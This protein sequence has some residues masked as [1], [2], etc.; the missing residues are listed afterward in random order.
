MGN[1]RLGFHRDQ[2]TPPHADPVDPH[3]AASPPLRNTSNPHEKSGLKLRMANTNRVLAKDE[4]VLPVMFTVLL[5][6]LP[7]CGVESSLH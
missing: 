2:W 3:F 6:L 1:L 4:C 7:K 5:M